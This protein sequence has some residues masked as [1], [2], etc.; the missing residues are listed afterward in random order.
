M[1]GIDLKCVV[2]NKIKEGIG[3]SGFCEDRV[4]VLLG[5]MIKQEINTILEKH[6]ST[7]VKDQ[8]P[9]VLLEILDHLNTSKKTT[10]KDTINNQSNDVVSTE[11]TPIHNDKPVNQPTTK[12]VV[13]RKAKAKKKVKRV[14]KKK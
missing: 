2:D 1:D 14:T 7:I 6:L 11:S 13:K 3:I 12:Q 9:D 8:Q 4:R 10:I 5:L